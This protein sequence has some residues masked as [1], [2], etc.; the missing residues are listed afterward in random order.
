MP[1]PSDRLMSR[2]AVGPDVGSFFRSGRE[3][4]RELRRT[5][6][7]ADRTLE[8]FASVLDFG[9]GCGRMLLWLE[10]IGLA[11]GLHGTDID[12]EAIDWC[13]EHIPFAEM[14]VNDQDPPLP[15]PDGTFDLVFNHSVFTHIDERRQDAWLA[16]LQ[17]VTRPGGLVV[18][19]THGEAAIPAGDD[20][21]R[22]TLEREGIAFL[23][24]TVP[25]TYSLPDWYQTT[26]HAPWYVFEH[27]GRWFQ[28]RAYV[29]GGSLRYQDHVLLQ[30]RA[31][32]QAA[33][34][35]LAAR[36]PISGRGIPEHR[37]RTALAI[38][39][40]NRDAAPAAPSHFGRLG[41]LAR[42]LLLRAMRPYSTH[43]DGF[44]EAVVAS[45]A[46]LARA[47]DHQSVLLER[48]DSDAQRPG[49]PT[50]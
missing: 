29:P 34:S 6:A 31:V 17:R 20:Q 36:P 21:L 12:A 15:Y 13:R 22:N 40:G 4:V 19:S 37:V 42:V 46:E 38:A 5:L 24:H 9:C 3:S 47:T 41:Q 43:E 39:R 26:F 33:R 45:I 10:G 16:E 44:D 25:R 49:E 28:V 18:L 2:V 50:P 11:G 35:P 23:D 7:I 30:R 48:L 14:A 1:V 8:S 32:D 27:W